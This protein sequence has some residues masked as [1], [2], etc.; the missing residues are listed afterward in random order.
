MEAQFAEF[1]IEQMNKTVPGHA[2]KSSAMN[3]YKQLQ[4]SQRAKVM[5][6]TGGGLGVQKV[7]LDQVYPKRFRNKIMYENYLKQTK[8]HAA[9]KAYQK[10][11]VQ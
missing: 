4:N 6:E 10:G 7:I 3:I 11:G 2:G 9:N 8:R 5:S 1:M